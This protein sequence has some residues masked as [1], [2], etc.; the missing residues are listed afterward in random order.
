MV[1]FSPL[2]KSF[3]SRQRNKHIRAISSGLPT[4]RKG[5]EKWSSGQVDHNLVFVSILEQWVT[6]IFHSDNDKANA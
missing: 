4:R 5:A 6:V 2:I 3:S 1:I